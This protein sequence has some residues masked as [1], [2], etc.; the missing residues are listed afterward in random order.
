[1]AKDRKAPYTPCFT[2]GCRIVTDR[3]AIAVE[4][5]CVG[6]RVL[7]RDHGYRPIRWIGAREFSDEQLRDYPELRPV[8]IAAGAL[9]GTLPLAD[10][11]VSPQHRMLVRGDAALA[12]DREILV[13]AIALIGQA[14]IAQAA[15]GGVIYFHLMFEA[16]EVICSEGAWSESFLPEAAALGGMHSAQLA[17]ILAIFPEL[18]AAKGLTAYGGAARLCADRDPVPG[19]ARA[20]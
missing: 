19:L 8:T 2:A 6:D 14:G 3:G 1:M 10:L 11:S 4:E 15:T 5:L 7:T 20:A 9:D 18:A 12:G 16:H 17:E 13:P